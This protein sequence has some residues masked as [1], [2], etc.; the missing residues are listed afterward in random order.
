MNLRWV[1]G[2][3]GMSR[4]PKARFKTISGSNRICRGRPTYFS[5]SNSGQRPSPKRD[6]V[7]E[8]I[9]TGLQAYAQTLLDERASNA[10][11]VNWKLIVV[12]VR[13]AHT[14]NPRKQPGVAIPQ[15]QPNP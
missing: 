6:T 14:N 9:A 11:V 5:S 1:Q 10:S 7:R 13:V 4:W 12:H 8:R 3:A 15:V 2:K